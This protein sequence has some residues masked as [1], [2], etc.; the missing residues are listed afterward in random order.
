MMGGIAA[1]GMSN[2]GAGIEAAGTTPAFGDAGTGF[3][4]G[5]MDAALSTPD[6]T[7]SSF[8]R[9]PDAMSAGIK[10]LAGGN[11]YGQAA[12]QF[13]TKAGLPSAGMALMG[14]SGV[15]A[16]DEGIEQGKA[17]DAAAAATRG[18]NQEMLNRIAAGKKRAQEAV[19][20]NP[21]MYAMGGSVDD[22]SGMDEAR[23]MM[24]G[25][26]QKGLFGMGYA[27][28]GLLAPSS[29]LKNPQTLPLA[30][31]PSNLPANYQEARN[32]FEKAQQTERE[33]F[34]NS[35][36]DPNRIQPGM[37]LT[38]IGNDQFG[39]QFGSATDAQKFNDF[40]KLYNQTQGPS[41]P[42]GN[43]PQVTP[44]VGPQ[45]TPMP[46]NNVTPP[47]M[48]GGSVG[49]PIPPARSNSPSNRAAYDA[50]Y[51]AQK[52]T[53]GLTSLLGSLNSS[54]VYDRMAR[55]PPIVQRPMQSRQPQQFANPNGLRG[56]AQP[57]RFSIFNNRNTPQKRF[58]EGGTP[59]FLSGGGDGM[60]DSIP[61]TIE[62]NQEA[63]LADGE[64]VIPADVVSHLGNGSSKAG[65]KQLYS[66]M[67][68]VRQARVGT[69]K[70]GKEIKPK[71]FMP[72]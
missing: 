1:Y 32:A 44:V 55:L 61:A 26:M 46:I 57:N 30:G 9:N 16:V 45:P 11:T 8:F 43:V 20:A 70:Q 64:F 4:T 37:G 41:A 65:A 63:R 12:T 18:E 47:P 28:G 10:N 31:T 5:S 40:Y 69:K 25:N 34:F 13:A 14:T 2:L 62:G 15:M 49:T 51:N 3:T 42:V 58:A 71:K 6:A 59:R 68:R 17:A 38:V 53:G 24:Q 48:Q 7:S 50:F 23:G 56:L 21:Y 39:Q 27:E 33:N 35:P 60:S 29:E 67:D 72:V 54:N 52:P 66:M 36:Y 19:R 22:E